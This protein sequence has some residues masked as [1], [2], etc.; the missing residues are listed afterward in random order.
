MPNL[1]GAALVMEVMDSGAAGDTASKTAL[2]HTKEPTRTRI[3]SAHAQ[4][5]TICALMTRIAATDN[6][7]LTTSVIHKLSPT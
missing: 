5:S 6:V 1:T 4:V 2:L 3:T 7:D